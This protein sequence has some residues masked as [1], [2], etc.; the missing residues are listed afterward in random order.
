MIFVIICI[1]V[2]LALIA[3]ALR[4]ALRERRDTTIIEHTDQF[5]STRR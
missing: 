3:M 1:G 5:W 4:N 2:F